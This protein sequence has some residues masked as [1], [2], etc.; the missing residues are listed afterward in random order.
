MADF[1][2]LNHLD[3]LTSDGESQGKNERSFQCPVCSSP[4]FKVTIAGSKEGQYFTHGC[5]CMHT[6]NRE[7]IHH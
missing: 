7:A 6:A 2:I 1:A 4:N 5:D 3:A